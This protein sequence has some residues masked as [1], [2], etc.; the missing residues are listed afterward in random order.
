LS[1]ST[2]A[3]CLAAALPS[4]KDSPA[5]ELRYTGELT[6][7]HLG[8]SAEPVKRFT[9]YG[10]YVREKNGGTLSYVL[11]E[12]GG[13]GWPWPERFGRIALNDKHQPVG[14]GT[15]RLLHTHDGTKY[16]V[17]VPTPLFPYAG[18]LVKGAEWKAGETRYEVVK[19]R[20][21]DKQKCWQVDVLGRIGR[22]RIA[23]VAVDS[24]IVVQFRQRVVMGQGD[25]FTLTGTLQSAKAV[26]ADR[27]VKLKKP[28]GT[29][30]Q[31]QSEL[32]R[33]KNQTRAE[34]DAEQL[35]KV[36]TALKTLKDDAEATPFQRLIKFIEGDFES[37]QKRDGDLDKLA[38]KITGKPGPQFS[39][40][41]LAGGS[42]AKKDLAGKIT[43]L[44]F[45]GY[46]GEPLEEPYGQVG[47]LDYLRSQ[48]QRRKLD[49]NIYGVAVDPRLANDN[50]ARLA[51]RS[52]R[53]LKNFMNLG[54][55]ITLDD[56]TVLKK[57]G[58][59]RTADAKLPLWVVIDHTGTVRSYKAGFYKIRADEGL[60]PLEQLLIKLV[61][62]QRQR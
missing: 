2:L 1:A 61:R 51:R 31:L 38:G 5:V 30:L 59:P 28:L 27:L 40:Q 6:P 53:R 4:L 43:V 60:R 50:T 58:D 20:T 21:V 55:P 44:H 45:W 57:F 19:Q 15:I 52:V 62:E 48:F 22:T 32:N 11:E 9:L 14:N 54:Y 3:I 39:L 35:A 49:V 18:K 10:L 16:P 17:T 41:T 29:L 13:G 24:P 26:E 7:A 23:L 37:Q 33:R 42:V 34:L 8:S 12:Q 36:G 47:Y 56:G 25:R 46:Q